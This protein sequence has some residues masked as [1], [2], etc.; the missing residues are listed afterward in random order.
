[1]EVGSRAPGSAPLTRFA[2]ASCRQPAAAP[3]R[4][5]ARTEKHSPPTLAQVRPSRSPRRRSPAAG[6]TH[7]PPV[8]RSDRQCKPRGRTRATRPTTASFAE[9]P[10]VSTVRLRTVRASSQR[11]GSSEKLS[12]PAMQDRLPR[13]PRNVTPVSASDASGVPLDGWTHRACVC[14]WWARGIFALAR[15]LSPARRLD[16]TSVRS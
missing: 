5:T 11:S 10:L 9:A 16:L 13:L 4:S 8:L 14:T 6:G 12:S 15:R 2:S 1:M 7:R 3:R